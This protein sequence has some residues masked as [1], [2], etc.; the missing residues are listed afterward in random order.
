MGSTTIETAENSR[1]WIDITKQEGV[2]VALLLIGFILLTI[3]VV[4][5][6][7]FIQKQIINF[8][9]RKAHDKAKGVISEAEKMAKEIIKD[10][11]SEA[12]DTR[13]HFE[14]EYTN[15]LQE[16]R[17]AI[18]D[19]LDSYRSDLEKSIADMTRVINEKNQLA[20]DSFAG[21]LN[22][23]E[24]NVVQNANQAKYNL[25]SIEKHVAE[26]ANDVKQR[27]ESLANQSAELINRLKHEMESV[28]G[29]VE[30]L[31][32]TLRQVAK[33][34]SDENTKIIQSELKRIAE[35]TAN[36]I[37]SATSLMNQTLEHTMTNELNKVTQELDHYRQ[38]R[39]QMID[40]RI[41]N[42]VEETTQIALH[43]EL[44]MQDQAELVYR[45]LEEAK[46]KG[47]FN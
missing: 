6:V 15:V 38:A 17:Q 44:S 33:D 23:I 2:E 39:Q 41:L 3:A 18:R 22:S 32:E 25:D 36:S 19:F 35:E 46:Q 42:L 8:R 5:T 27:F 16:D 31:S 37:A 34:K 40:E 7:G 26:N 4:L 43:K 28:E 1:T 14:E 29:G 20:S 24:Q 11:L 45:S 9:Y 13:T 30:Q 21:S 12:G 10:T 47:I